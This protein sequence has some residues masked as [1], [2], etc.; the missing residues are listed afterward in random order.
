M[1]IENHNFKK[2]KINQYI[3]TSLYWLF[4]SIFYTSD[5]IEE[6][7]DKHKA[8][9]KLF[10]EQTQTNTKYVIILRTLDIQSTFHTQQ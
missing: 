8:N 2:E 3:A 1:L 5:N 7:E 10:N 6:Q 9:N 4:Y